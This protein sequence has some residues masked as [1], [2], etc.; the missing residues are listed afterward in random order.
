MGA[1]SGIGFALAEAFVSR[2]V[3][4]GVAA[5]RTD[6]LISLQNR[7]PG[8]VEYAA[9]DITHRDATDKLSELIDRIGGLD[10]YIHVSG[11]GYRNPELDPELEV[12]ILNTNVSGFARMVAHT[13]RYF[14]N[15]GIKGHIAAVTSVAGTKG[16]SLMP[17]YSASKAMDSAYL[18]ALAQL[19]KNEGSDITI[20]DIRPGWVT[21][22]LLNPNHRYP[23]QMETEYIVPRILK[24]IAS[25]QR[26]AV[27]D[28]RWNLLVGLWQL[29]P[30]ALWIRMRIPMS[31]PTDPK[32]L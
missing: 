28:W 10:L 14:R 32:A 7:Y 3:K 25:K 11:I 22:P 20:T 16:V 9:I 8:L 24:A 4:I 21:T 27:I 17:A 26:V 15:H 23:L 31:N 5:R 6:S 30:N 12:N 13:Y 29:I 1:S 18:L 19:S 2:G